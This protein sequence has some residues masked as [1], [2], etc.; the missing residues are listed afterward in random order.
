[1]YH[2]GRIQLMFL[3]PVLLVHAVS[4]EERG[5][6]SQSTSFTSGS[7]FLINFNLLLAQTKENT[8]EL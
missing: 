8:N 7:L 6:V 4:I 1:M 3:K 5:I 2:E